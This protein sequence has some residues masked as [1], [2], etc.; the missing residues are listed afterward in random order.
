MQTSCDRLFL[1]K[2]EI[3][4]LLWNRRRKWWVAA[5]GSYNKQ[6]KKRWENRVK[7]SFLSAWQL[8]VWC[9]GSQPADLWPQKHLKHEVSCC[10]Q[11]Q[12]NIWC[13]LSCCFT[14]TACWYA[15]CSLITVH[16]LLLLLLLI[17]IILIIHFIFRALFKGP[18]CRI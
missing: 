18:V 8:Q 7:V 2:E 16:L 4:L 12:T 15:A 1:R 10:L 5:T 14:F 13:S 3:L 6:K 9:S 11:H 17:I